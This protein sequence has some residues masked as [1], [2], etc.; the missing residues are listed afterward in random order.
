MYS[1]PTYFTDGSFNYET[2]VGGL[3]VICPDGSSYGDTIIGVDPV[4]TELMALIRAVQLVPIGGQAVIVSDCQSIIHQLQH[5][6]DYTAVPK[7]A[8]TCPANGYLFQQL[9]AEL[10]LRSIKVLWFRG[11]QVASSI[12]KYSLAQFNTFNKVFILMEEYMQLFEGNRR[13]DRV[14]KGIEPPTNFWYAEDICI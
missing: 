1:V 12:D 4:K 11:H 8:Q 6:W 14:A 10:D 5:S 7:R 9:K 3:A 13:A 2:Q